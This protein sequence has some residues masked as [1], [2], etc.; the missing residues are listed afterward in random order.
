MTQ[1]DFFR[2]MLLTPVFPPIAEST[3]ARSVVG[4]L[5]KLIPLLYILATNP[6][7]SPVIPPPTPINKSDLLKFFDNRM[8]KIKSP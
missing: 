4:I 1:L 7:T 2:E 6:A 5:I 3:W 8:F